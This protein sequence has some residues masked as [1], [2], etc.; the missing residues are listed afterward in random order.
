VEDSTAIV[1]DQDE[2]HRGVRLT[3]PEQPVLIVEKGHIAYRAHHHSVR[4]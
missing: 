2:Y 3:A 1:V 4:L